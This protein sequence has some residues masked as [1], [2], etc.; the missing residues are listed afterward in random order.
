V[1]S[2]GKLVSA[3][4][5][6]GVVLAVVASPACYAYLPRDASAQLVGDTVQFSL[7]DMGTVALVPLVGPG[8]GSVEG[9]LA[10]DSADTYIVSVTKTTRRDGTESDWRSERV[11][12]A[13]SL[14]ASVGVRRFSRG[15][16]ILFGALTTGALLAI[17][18]AFV[19]SGGATVPG[20]TPTGPPTGR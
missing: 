11:A 10:A 17:A 15:R 14:V 5:R 6:I 1:A 12:I 7:T 9:R 8:V 18:E 2:L 3:A 19:G 4:T 16:T 20:G 13:H